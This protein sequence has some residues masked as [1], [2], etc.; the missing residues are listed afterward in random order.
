[1]SS[2]RLEPEVEE[3]VRQVARLLG[4]TQSE[5][6]RRA[7]EQFCEQALARQRGRSRYSDVI[8]VG[9]GPP[10]LSWRA[11]EVFV[12]VLQEGQREPGHGDG[13]PG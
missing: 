4:L 3:R 7:L 6:H 1:M 9:T 13:H 12:E 2:V 8:G 10:D 11:D 5:V